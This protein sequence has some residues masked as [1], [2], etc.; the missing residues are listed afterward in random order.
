MQ[1][2]QRAAGPCSLP[3][4]HPEQAHT[5]AGVV[6]L[7]WHKPGAWMGP[8]GQEVGP[9]VTMQEGHVWGGGGG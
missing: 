8:S 2:V 4:T 9:A 6:V 1:R 3:H 5:Q 7:D